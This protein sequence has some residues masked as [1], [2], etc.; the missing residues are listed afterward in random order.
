MPNACPILE[1]FLTTLCFLNVCPMLD[2]FLVIDSL[3]SFNKKNSVS[4]DDDFKALVK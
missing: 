3:L 4:I 1:V 2:I